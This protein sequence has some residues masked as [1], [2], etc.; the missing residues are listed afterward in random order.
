MATRVLPYGQARA[1]QGMDEFRFCLFVFP[2]ADRCPARLKI[3]EIAAGGDLPVGILPR[4]PDLHVIGL[5]GG[6]TEVAGAQ[7]HDPVRDPELLE[8]LLG[9][10]RELLQLR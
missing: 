8:H 2:E 6:E 1:V 3:L 5:G 4:Q 9:I 10:R 7:A